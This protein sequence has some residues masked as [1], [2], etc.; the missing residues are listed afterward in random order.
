MTIVNPVGSAPASTPSL[1]ATQPTSAPEQTLTAQ[2]FMQLLVTQLENQDPTQPMDSA[3]MVQQTTELGMMQEMSS[4]QTNT[5][6]SVTLQSQAIAADLMGKTI[7]Y[8]DA[9]GASA[10]GVVSAVT[11]AGTAPTV[12]VNGATVGLGNILGVTQTSAS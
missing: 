11:F 12:T 1:Y 2:D 6:S 3:A 10:S 5:T 7:T 4:V 9:A 8:T